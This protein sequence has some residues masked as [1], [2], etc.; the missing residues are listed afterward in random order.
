[1]DRPLS[2][3][4]LTALMNEIGFSVTVHDAKNGNKGQVYDNLVPCT[5]LTK[6][7]VKKLKKAI[8]ELDVSKIFID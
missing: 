5:V 2:Y 8:P 4:E 7:L 3:S 1:M 6:S